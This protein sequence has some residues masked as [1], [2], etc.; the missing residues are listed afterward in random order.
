MVYI[1]S[2]IDPHMHP[3][4]HPFT[5]LTPPPPPLPTSP[6]HLTSLAAHPYSS[7]MHNGSDITTSC[8]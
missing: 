5:Q 8:I 2:S 7:R 4:M 3:A 6:P 1:P